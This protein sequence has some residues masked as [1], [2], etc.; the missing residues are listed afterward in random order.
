MA[1]MTAESE[2][3]PL[4]GDMVW[5]KERGIASVSCFLLVILLDMLLNQC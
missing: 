5:L 3:E 1:R 4:K 2:L